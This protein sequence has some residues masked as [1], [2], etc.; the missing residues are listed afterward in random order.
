MISLHQKTVNGGPSKMV[1]II[2]E[3]ISEIEPL[4]KGTNVWTTGNEPWLVE[5]D[6]AT[7]SMLIDKQRKYWVDYQAPIPDTI[8]ELSYLRSK[9]NALF[10]TCVTFSILVV[11]AVAYLFFHG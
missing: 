5:E 8:L 7:I 3:H 4:A 2:E 10:L 9:I 1:H 6:A 11:L